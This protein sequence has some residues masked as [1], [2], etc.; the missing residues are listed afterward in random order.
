MTFPAGE[1]A[2]AHVFLG[3]L[4]DECTIE[5][6]DGHHLQRV[7][8]LRVGEH[9]TAADGA[10]SWRRYE[11]VGS[12]RGRIVVAARS[13]IAVEPD[14]S[15]RVGMAL[16]LTKGGLDAVVA[17][18]T[19]LGVAWIEPVASRRSVARWDAPRA[20]HAL[21]RLRSVAREAA[22]QSRRAR[23]PE[24]RP[25]V[26]VR[27]LADRAGLVLADRAGVAAAELRP[28]PG[29]EWTVL[30]GP[31][32][33]FD[34]EEL[35]VLAGVAR[36]AVGRHVLRAETAPVAAAAALVSQISPGIV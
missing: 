10:G 27:A 6:A 14:P 18:V 19:E 24:I 1:D 36:L 15:P 23:I 28:P 21:A 7:R 33:G 8:R 13:A 9:V 29:G 4:D 30:V 20:E 16:A 22:A 32:G 17:R 3:A 11:I 26:S 34:P 25:L 2:S 5:G 12:E 35:D 31:E